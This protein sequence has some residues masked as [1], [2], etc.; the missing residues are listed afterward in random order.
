MEILV[1][2]RAPHGFMDF[3]AYPEKLRPGQEVTVPERQG[4]I[5]IGSDPSLELV[6]RIFPPV[7]VATPDPDNPDWK[8]APHYVAMLNKNG[9]MDGIE[10]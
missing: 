4:K 3:N 8:P 9:G 5:M 6:N 7:K 10:T 1:V 2:I